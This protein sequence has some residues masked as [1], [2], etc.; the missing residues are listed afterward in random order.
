MAFL[1]ASTPK[2]PMLNSAADKI[3]YQESGMLMPTSYFLLAAT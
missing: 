1:R 2:R 3:K